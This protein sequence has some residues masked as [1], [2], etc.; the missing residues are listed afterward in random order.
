[1]K[2]VEI[3]QASSHRIEPKCEVYNKCGG[4]AL[5]HLS[6]DQQIVYKQQQL[7]DNLQK[8]GGVN[9]SKI[10]PPI[11][12]DA[13]SYRRRSRFG[14]TF[15]QTKNEVRLGFRARNT[16]FIQPTKTC[17]IL[18]QRI[19]NLLPELK[20]VL[21]QLRCNENVKGVDLC[22]A[23]SGLSALIIINEFMNS[24]DARRLVKFAK[25][26][27]LQIRI[28]HDKEPEQLLFPK[29]IDQT[30]EPKTLLR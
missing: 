16:H 23:D 15:A 28:Q 21:S 20:A 13:W 22:A 27:N 12:G 10:L 1:M 11:I 25:T 29:E 3:L 5:Q 6:T 4:C 7:I 14:A 19:A 8:I 9:A 26:N 2:A 18:D 24:D 17:H 30:K